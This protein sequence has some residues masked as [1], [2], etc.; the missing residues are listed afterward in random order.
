MKGV[1]MIQNK[2]SRISY[3]NRK[4]RENPKEKWIIVENMHTPIIDKKIFDKVQKMEIVQKYQR[5]EK[6]NYTLLGDL[7]VCYECGHKIGI[8]VDSRRKDTFSIMC[9]NYRRNP[10]LHLCTCHGFR[11]D[12]IEGKV[13]KDVRELFLKIDN[14]K[15]EMNL[16]KGKTVYDYKKLM[17][18]NQKEIETIKNKKITVYMDKVDNKI[19]EEMYQMVVKKYD[20]E[21]LEKEQE[22]MEM[23]KCQEESEE[24]NS[25]DITKIVKEFLSLEEPTPELM[26]VIINRIKIHQ[27]K[28]IDIIFNF[29]ELNKI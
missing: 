18:K 29:K 19:N 12:Q 27:D 26:K 15:I 2:R 22:Y 23:K 3:K 16:K 13:L 8:K 7:L 20:Q 5:N 21:I 14:N 4:M 9:N 28:Q 10:K 6:K 24:D 17:E 11:Y 1:I 25:K